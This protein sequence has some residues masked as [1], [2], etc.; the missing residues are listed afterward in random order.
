MTDIIMGANRVLATTRLSLDI[1]LPQDVTIDVTAL[2]LYADGKVRGDGDMCF[3]NQP[4]IWDRAVTLS[5]TTLRRPRFDFDLDRIPSEVE[6]IVLTATIDTPGKTFGDT[7]SIAIEGPDLS[8]MV[9]N[10]GRQEA[11]LILCE[12]YKRNGT[13]KI[14]NISQGFNGGLAALATHFGVELQEPPTSTPKSSPAP[15]APAVPPAAHDQSAQSSSPVNITKVSL[16]KTDKSVSLKKDGSR[17]GKIRVNLNWNQRKKSG[18]LFKSKST[19]LD[20]DLGAFVED[21]HGKIKAVQ[22]LGN[23]F[24][25]FNTFPYVKLLGDDRTGAATDGEWLEINGDQWSEIRRILI[26][27]FIY[28]GAPNWRET[29]GVI[30]LMVP[31]QP[32]IEV[33]MN[34][35]GSDLGTCAV[36]YLENK[37][38][39]IKVSRELTFHRGQRVMDDAYDWG[40]KWT[41]GRK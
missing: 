1:I 5:S 22:A 27:A 3:Y 19:A 28:D 39:E 41:K 6:K 24:G 14:R 11:A 20:L 21:R 37:N 38:G 25:D 26:Y 8:M 35:Y 18:G 12:I 10:T 15:V 2:T 33:R 30:R 9:E 34:E 4:N 32:E 40:L 31:G 23:S 29:D 13:W 17:F 16:T 36:A 7:A